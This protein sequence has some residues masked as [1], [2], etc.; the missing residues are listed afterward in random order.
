MST[1]P[2][3]SKLRKEV[4]LDALWDFFPAALAEVARCIKA[5]ADQHCE[6]R[7][8][9]DRAKST[10]HEACWLRHNVDRREHARDSD[11]VLHLSKMAWRS[12]AMLQL[13][14]EQH[15]KPVAPAA[16]LPEYPHG[17]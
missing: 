5:G 8:E 7:I 1:L 11:E 9:W 15:G 14:C 12:L 17:S 13:W 16:K 2:T 3:D 4:P 6:G 10:D